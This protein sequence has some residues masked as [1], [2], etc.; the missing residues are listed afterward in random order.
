[1]Q[2]EWPP[3]TMT[4]KELGPNPTSSYCRLPC[5]NLDGHPWVVQILS[6]CTSMKRGNV[7]FNSVIVE[8]TKFVGP[9]KSRMCQYII[10]ACCS[11]AQP[12]WS[13]INSGG[14]YH[15]RSSEHESRQLTDLSIWYSSLSPSY[16][17][18]S[19]IVLQIWSVT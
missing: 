15:I 8:A 10:N 6:Q 19:Q 12:M 9:Y 16:L 2:N 18:R 14:W 17:A 1:M 7:S 13:L 5:D 3:F 11:R 4:I